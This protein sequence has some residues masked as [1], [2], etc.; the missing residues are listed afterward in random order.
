MKALFCYSSDKFV[1]EEMPVPRIKKDE[2]LMEM[3]Y[4][5]LCG[6][7][8]I[9]IFDPEVKKPAVFGHEVVGRIVETGNDVEKFK[10]GDLVVAAHHIPCYRC[11]YCLHGNY[12]MCRHF[13]DTNIY[14]GAFSQYIKLSKEHI[15]YTVFKIPSGSNLLEVLFMEPL[16]CCVRAMDRVNFLKNDIFAVV[17]TGV[18]GML[19]IQLI[20]L[21]GGRAAAVDID[22][23]RLS[24]AG[25]LGAEFT[26]N[27]LKSNAVKKIKEFTGTGADIAVLSVTNTSTLQAALMY[28]R[29]GGTALI[30]GSSENKSSVEVNFWNIYRRELSIISSYSAAPDA[31]KRS[32]DLITGGKLN[33]SPLISKAIPLEDFKK[34]LDL[35]LQN[36][37]YKAIFK[38]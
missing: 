1:L 22:D 27:P 17:G 23:K 25:K 34:G 37:V 15:D 11:Q 20:K 4:T 5:G 13:K 28:L 6:S 7:D 24:L 32:Y 26:I 21:M 12:S 36:K 9:K 29:E 38:I 18:M 8:I 16:A 31:L 14:P 2:M 33:L 10:K 3:V 30:F 19:F 35:M